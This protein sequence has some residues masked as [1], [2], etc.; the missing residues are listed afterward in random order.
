MA[1]ISNS[2]I[3]SW[4]TF[5]GS[6]LPNSIP[7]CQLRGGSDGVL[8]GNCT[9]V[10]NTTLLLLDDAL[11]DNFLTCGLWATLA[12][13][14]FRNSVASPD[15]SAPYPQA[16]SLLARFDSLG[17]DAKDTIYIF[18]ATSAVGNGLNVLEKVTR[19]GTS[20]ADGTLKRRLQS[21]RAVFRGR[22]VTR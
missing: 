8:L 14:E 11:P 6:N 3:Q 1:G 7:P 22:I 10:C 15:H 16:S 19:D 5:E 4:L 20:Q 9:Q 12:V 21:G 2:S 13:Q 17:L 18:A